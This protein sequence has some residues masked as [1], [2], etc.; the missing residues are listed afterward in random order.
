MSWVADVVSGDSPSHGTFR[1]ISSVF[2]LNSGFR[3]ESSVSL[4]NWVADEPDGRKGLDVGSLVLYPNGAFGSVSSVSSANSALGSCSSD[5]PLNSEIGVGSN[6]LLFN[7]AVDDTEGRQGLDVGFFVLSPN[8]AFGSVS[9]ASSENS[10]WG[11]VS[12]DSPG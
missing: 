4:N 7:K 2:P 10:A 12:S 6:G 8:R 1:S 5:F 3:V 9:S 11:S